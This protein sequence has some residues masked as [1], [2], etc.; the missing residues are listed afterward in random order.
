MA[1]KSLAVLQNR[2]VIGAAKYAATAAGL[3]LVYL[4]VHKVK[5]SLQTHHDSFVRDK[6]LGAV[7]E[8][9]L[10]RITD[11]DYLDIV[12][13]LLEFYGMSQDLFAH[14]CEAIAA[15]CEFKRSLP[16]KVMQH[17]VREYCS[18]AHKVINAVRLLRNYIELKLPSVLEDFDQVASDISGKY[19]EDYESLLFDSQLRY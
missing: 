6:L 19:D 10:D 9:V 4:G 12:Y 2:Y 18:Q 1:A 5:E 16:P 3:S 11:D 8:S 15:V 17:H 7:P 14:V 13:R